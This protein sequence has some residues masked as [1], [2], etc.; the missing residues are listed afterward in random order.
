[1]AAETDLTNQIE[2]L[3]LF[4]ERCGVRIDGLN[5]YVRRGGATIAIMG[6]IHARDGAALDHDIVLVAAVYDSL[7][8]VIAREEKSIQ[9]Y[10]FFGFDTFRIIIDFPTQQLTKIRLYPQL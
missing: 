2:R 7:S 4:E 9:A 6:E 8:R 10:K 3:E 5:A 1:M